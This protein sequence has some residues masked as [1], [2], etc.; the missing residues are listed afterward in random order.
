MTMVLETYEAVILVGSAIS[1]WVVLAMRI[2]RLRAENTRLR[3]PLPSSNEDQEKAKA[4]A[5]PTIADPVF[6]CTRCGRTAD[7][8]RAAGCARGPCPMEATHG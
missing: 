6:R 1:V 5:I 4:A 3:P 7:E 2:D 8:A